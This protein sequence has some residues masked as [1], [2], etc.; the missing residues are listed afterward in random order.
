MLIFDSAIMSSTIVHVSFLQWEFKSIM[1]AINMSVE[2]R[3]SAV[4]THVQTW[5]LDRNLL[6]L[7][8]AVQYGETLSTPQ[9]KPIPT[10]T[11][12]SPLRYSFPA[13]F[14]Q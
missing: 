11:C 1:N 13:S 5:S 7:V 10:G 14:Q 2:S 4:Q 8:S 3:E 9:Q 12:K 6:P